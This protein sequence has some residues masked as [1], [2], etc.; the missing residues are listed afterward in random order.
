MG[1]KRS[2]FSF[3]AALFKHKTDVGVQLK[4]MLATLETD[5]EDLEDSVKYVGVIVYVQHAYFS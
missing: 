1:P 5:L 2:M 4:A 3:N